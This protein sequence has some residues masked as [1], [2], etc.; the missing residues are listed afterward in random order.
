MTHDFAACRVE[1]IPPGVRPRLEIV[2]EHRSPA[3]PDAVE[4]AWQAK[5]AANPRLFDAPTLAFDSAEASR[6]RIGARRGTY[7][8]L[9][10]QPEVDCGFVHVGCTAALLSR[11][12]A[13]R[14]HTLLGRRAAGT[15]VHGGM[16][17]LGP[18]GGVDP[19][20]ASEDHL[21]DVELWRSAL[22]EIREEVGLDVEPDPGRA[23]ALVHD[24]FS[25]SV[26]L[27]YEVPLVRSVEELAVTAGDDAGTSRWE[28]DEVRWIGLDEIAAFDAREAG[29]IIPPTRALF[30][31]LGWIGLSAP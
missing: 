2:G 10:V 22:A 7:K 3:D 31:A 27:V 25:S 5:R 21:T 19:P 29:R 6:G 26:D 24:P 23:V 1:R 20:P 4:R 28:Y 15:R 16:W 11:D 9:A 30:R 12:A 13:G 14:A 18:S 8:H 17:E